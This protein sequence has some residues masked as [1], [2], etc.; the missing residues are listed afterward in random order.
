MAVVHHRDA[1]QAMNHVGD[2]HMEKR[3]VP[4]SPLVL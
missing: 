3:A 1:G 4:I 2:R